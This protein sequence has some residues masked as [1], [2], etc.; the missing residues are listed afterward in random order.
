MEREE[1]K[2]K[3]IEAINE[4][5]DSDGWCNILYLG[6]VIKEKELTTKN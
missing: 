4:N 2:T 5:L 1:I 3:L 6:K